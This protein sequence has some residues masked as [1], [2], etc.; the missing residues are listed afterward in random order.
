M[1]SSLQRPESTFQNNIYNPSSFTCTKEK[2]MNP[3]KNI[4]TNGN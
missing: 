3:M 2:A 4:F 1:P